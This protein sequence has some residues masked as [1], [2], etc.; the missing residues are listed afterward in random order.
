[1]VYGSHLLRQRSTNFTFSHLRSYSDNNRTHSHLNMAWAYQRW[2]CWMLYDAVKVL[3]WMDRI[4]RAVHRAHPHLLRS[5]SGAFEIYWFRSRRV[6]LLWHF[7]PTKKNSWISFL[8]LIYCLFSFFQ[9]YFCMQNLY[10]GQRYCCLWSFWYSLCQVSQFITFSLQIASF[11]NVGSVHLIHLLSMHKCYPI[12][13]HLQKQNNYRI[14]C[15]P[16]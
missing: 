10:S 12:F 7:V 4:V 5:V 11:V 9:I 3:L 13:V 2:I 15:L 8:L 1:M 6:Y 14:F 16:V